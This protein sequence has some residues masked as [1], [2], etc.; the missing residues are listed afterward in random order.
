MIVPLHIRTGY[1]F[2]KSS[3]RIEKLFEKAKNLGYEALGLCDL[4]NFYALPK[5]DKCA[6]SYKF[7]SIY[8]TEIKIESNI[9]S[10]Y[11]L[12]EEGYRNINKIICF[13]I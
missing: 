11:A 6:K 12:N 1:S 13:H 4:S 8:G 2:L 10:F 5:F 3:I 7:S 9:L